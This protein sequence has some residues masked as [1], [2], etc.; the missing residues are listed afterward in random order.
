MHGPGAE[1]AGDIILSQLPPQPPMTLAAQIEA[2]LAVLHDKTAKG[3]CNPT[4]C[5][6]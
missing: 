6:E 4:M 1:C 2:D 5:A 3:K